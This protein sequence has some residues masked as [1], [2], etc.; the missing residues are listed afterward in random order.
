MDSF[1]RWIVTSSD[2]KFW[3]WL[4][5]FVGS[6]RD[7]AGFTG[8]IAVIDYGLTIQQREILEEQRVVCLPAL[9]NRIQV[10]DRYLSLASYFDPSIPALVA[11]F[12]ADIWFNRTINALFSNPALRSGRLGAAID[13]FSCDYYYTCSPRARHAEVDQLLKEVKLAFGE[14]L[15]AGMIIAAPHLWMHFANLL[16]SLIEDGHAKSCWGADALAL[17]RFACD[18]PESFT[19]LPISYNAPPLW[20]FE[21]EGMNLYATEPGGVRKSHQS[22]QRVPIAAVHRTSGARCYKEYDVALADMHPNVAQ[23]WAQIFG[24]RELP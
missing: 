14:P 18:H 13:V 2:E 22:A 21:R 24:I 12:D 11:H 23:R 4:A 15:Q 7:V 3:P 16:E 6:L 17:N 1:E 10:L 8:S 20:K 9:N 19:L 5:M